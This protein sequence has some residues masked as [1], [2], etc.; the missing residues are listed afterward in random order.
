MITSF[1]IFDSEYKSNFSLKVANKRL[2]LTIKQQIS[3][4]RSLKYQVPISPHNQILLCTDNRNILAA[5][6]L[7]RG[8]ESNGGVKGCRVSVAEMPKSPNQV[9]KGEWLENDATV[10]IP[11][12]NV[13]EAFEVNV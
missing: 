13:Q 1:Q 12:L 6:D 3:L 2:Y 9:G 5:F 10:K 4:T 7:K 11:K 8:L